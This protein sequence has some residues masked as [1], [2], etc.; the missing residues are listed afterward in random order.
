MA[1]AYVYAP[2]S[3][4][5][6]GKQN[7]CD[8]TPTTPPTPHTVVNTLGGGLPI[9]IGDVVENTSVYFR[10]SSV[11]KSVVTT[12]A[13]VCKT[14]T[15]DWDQGVVVKMYTGYNGTGS[16]I[17]QVAY[18]H[19]RNWIGNGTHNTNNL[20][21]GRMP[22]DCACGCSDGIHVHMQCGNGGTITSLAACAGVN[23]YAGSTWIYRLRV[24]L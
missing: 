5:I 17:S 10:G 20:W 9:D 1:Y 2:F 13:D 23:V 12:R 11:I 4:E 21:L 8:G 3:G 6:W 18:G 7:Y 15:G 19:L 16:L 14:Q 22:N 24:P